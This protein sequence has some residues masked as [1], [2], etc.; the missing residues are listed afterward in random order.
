MAFDPQL[1][2]IRFG[3]GLSPV[4]APP[5]SVAAMMARLRGPDLMASR[6]PISEFAATKPDVTDFR[7]MQALVADPATVAE[8]EAL[9]AALAEE[10]RL[11]RHR[12]F[13]ASLARAVH[14]PDGLRERLVQFWAS[15]FALRSRNFMTHHLVT[16][17]V[18]SA[19]RTHV[20][21]DFATMLRGVVTHPMMILY[22]DQTASFGPNSRSARGRGLNENLAREV[23]ELHT[24]GA[25]GP[26]AQDDVVQFAEALT[27]LIWSRRDM[28]AEYRPAQAEPGAEI[29]LGVTYG[30]DAD[31]A[32]IHQILD[33]LARHPATAR[34]LAWKMAH[35]FVSDT[36]DP[37][38]V[39][40]M[41]GAYGTGDLGAMTEAMLSHPAAW[42]PVRA[43][44]RW[45]FDYIAAAARALHVPDAALMPATRQEGQRDFRNFLGLMGQPWEEPPDPSGWPDV[46][47]AWVSAQFLAARIDW[48]MRVP[49]RLLPDLP[50]PRAF[51]ATAF[52]GPPPEVARA[53]AAAEDRRTGI[54]VIL[55]SAAFQRR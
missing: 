26:Y 9:K 34:H 36:P 40:A 30:A 29:I 6:Y 55:A 46:A 4:I 48:A 13:G 32:V 50:D 22:L 52:A 33:D 51:V 7:A 18:E 2:A 53:A 21:G 5:E 35:H 11:I 19:I 49:V 54:G 16:P 45:P 44:V 24:L 31:I 3:T 8:G 15:H 20:A 28:A 17:F 14:A 37:D 43:K 39:E 47:E 42:H 12:H 10:Q 38:L 41:A 27:G 1:A 25:D 23:L